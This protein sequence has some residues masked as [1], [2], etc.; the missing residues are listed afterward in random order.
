MT[1]GILSIHF[2]KE[3]TDDEIA[4][5]VRRMHSENMAY[6]AG[7]QYREFEETEPVDKVITFIDEIIETD[8]GITT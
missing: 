2:N 7:M 6:I 3:A 8:P 1:S 5:V 4:M